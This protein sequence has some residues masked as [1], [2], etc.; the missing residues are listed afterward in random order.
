MPVDLP[1]ENPPHP[2]CPV[3]FVDSRVYQ[4]DEDV[5]VGYN[6]FTRLTVR[7]NLLSAEYVDLGGAVQ[8]SES[9]RVDNGTLTRTASKTGP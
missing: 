3:E 2:E 5:Q 9:W 7:D 1:P 4:S 6:G 8:F